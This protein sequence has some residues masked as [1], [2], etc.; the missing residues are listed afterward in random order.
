MQPLSADRNF[1]AAR[2]WGRHIKRGALIVF[3]ADAG[4]G[5][6]FDKLRIR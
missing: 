2:P 1:E 6:S 4:F 3:E 5:A